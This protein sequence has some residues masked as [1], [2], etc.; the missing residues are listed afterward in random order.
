MPT[1]RKLSKPKT[2]PS[3]A[4][5]APNQL[6]LIRDLAAILNETG[7]TEIELD[8]R[9]ARVKVSKSVVAQI[10]PLSTAAH[11]SS[12]PHPAAQVAQP[13]ATAA[14][15]APDLANALKSPMVGTVYLASSPSAAPFIEIGTKVKEGQTVLIIEAMKTM[16]QIPSPRAGTVTRILVENGQPVEYGEA[17]LIIE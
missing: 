13:N 9:G 5:Q 14:A 17:M 1:K 3:A 8:H 15:S 4:T 12:V 10:A 6:D 16:N 2:I 7:L 11:T